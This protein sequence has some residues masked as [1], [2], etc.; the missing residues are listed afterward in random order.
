MRP[1][2]TCLLLLCVSTVAHAQNAPRG[3]DLPEAKAFDFWIGTWDLTWTNAEGDVVQG[4]T[5]VR[6][7]LDDCVIEEN[8]V[9]PTFTGRSYSVYDPRMQQWRQTWIDSQ[10][11]FLVFTGGM[12]GD[13][14]ELRMEP[15][16][17]DDGRTLVRR[18]VFKNISADQL[19]WDWQ[20]SFDGGETWEDL[21]KI[22]YAR[23]V[24]KSAST[25]Q[26]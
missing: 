20:R 23:R 2:L 14:M 21:W 3:C 16:T 17:T 18:M 8:F 9:S 7:V 13:R 25:G 19:D 4:E 1:L 26:D 24:P 5:V 10:G 22:H 11:G 6:R 15:V 12:K